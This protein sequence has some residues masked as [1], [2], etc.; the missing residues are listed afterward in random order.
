MQSG[1][2]NISRLL[3]G[4]FS[5]VHAKEMNKK[6][7]SIVTNTCSTMENTRNFDNIESLATL[8]PSCQ[9]DDTVTILV[10]TVLPVLI[11]SVVSFWFLSE[12]YRPS[13]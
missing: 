4:S 10:V 1:Y 7:H 12:Y 11:L 13:R 5:P 9:I 3:L 2:R 6:E 8:V